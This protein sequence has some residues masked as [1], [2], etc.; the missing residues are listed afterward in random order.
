EIPDDDEQDS[1]GGDPRFGASFYKLMSFPVPQVQFLGKVGSICPVELVESPSQDPCSRDPQQQQT[2]I[3]HQ[4]GR[5]FTSL[6][7]IPRTQDL[8]HGVISQGEV[9]AATQEEGESL[10]LRFGIGPN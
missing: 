3:G 8:K 2:R 5:I 1:P 6:A 7:R 9:A 4:P 10:E